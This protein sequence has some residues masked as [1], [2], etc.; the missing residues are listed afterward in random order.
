MTEAQAQLLFFVILLLC[1][2]A[3]TAKVAELEKRD[4]EWSCFLFL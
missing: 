3:I 4:N 1:G 2:G